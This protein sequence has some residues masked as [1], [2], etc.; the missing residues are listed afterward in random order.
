[1]AGLRKMDARNL[2]VRM[3]LLL[4]CRKCQH[5]RYIEYNRGSFLGDFSKFRK[6][7]ISFVLSVRSSVHMEQHCSNWDGFHEI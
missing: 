2:T 4:L 6:V 7:T 5:L 3:C 1:M